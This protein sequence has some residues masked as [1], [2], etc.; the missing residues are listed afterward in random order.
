MV[1][2]G[3]KE[4]D[5]RWFERCVNVLVTVGVCSIGGWGSPRGCE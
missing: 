4:D 3:Y 2:G 5:W 1:S